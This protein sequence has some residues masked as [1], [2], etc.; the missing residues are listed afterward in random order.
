[1][2]RVIILGATGS[3]ARKVI[4]YL[5]GDDD[6]EI[7]G[8]SL[9]KNL[10]KLNEILNEINTISN[11][12]I[13]NSKSKFNIDRKINYYYGNDANI[14][15]I[16]ATKADLIINCIY[17]SIAFNPVFYA[18]KRNIKVYN[19]NKEIF[20]YGFNELKKY[21]NLLIPLDP[22][23]DTLMQLKEKKIN[24]NNYIEFITNGGPL[25][26]YPLD[27]LSSA[28]NKALFKSKS[29]EEGNRYSLDNATSIYIYKTFIEAKFYFDLDLDKVN[30]IIND[31]KDEFIKIDNNLYGIN[32]LFSHSLKNELNLIQK[33]T[34]EEFNFDKNRY[35]LLPYLFKNYKRYGDKLNIS[36]NASNEIGIGQFLKNSI[37]FG[38]LETLVRRVT[39][40]V[41]KNRENPSNLKE[42]EMLY[43][44]SKD[45]AKS[46]SE[47]SIN[48]KESGLN[49][50]TLKRNQKRK[51]KSKKV[52]ENKKRDEMRR[53]KMSRWRNDPNKKELLEEHN[54]KR[55][56]KKKEIESKEKSSLKV[57]SVKENEFP[58]FINDIDSNH[59]LNDEQHSY[60]KKVKSR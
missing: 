26:D 19:I 14:E 18:L 46:L 49:K 42:T 27:K 37:S 56:K 59:R 30:P 48:I 25:K 51:D 36:L 12:A 58:V 20:L 1:M 29:D 24:F 50:K 31:N 38:D 4:D 2:K 57:S 22:Y 54:K 55:I 10:E 52:E 3:F 16:N 28:Y 45:L 47:K 17:G 33:E 9:Y 35:P 8:I 34:R 40:E 5:K 15:L 41:N 44:Y 23:I 39:S 7:V 32:D 6:Y 21:K 53:K 11:V 60:K 13:I 43:D